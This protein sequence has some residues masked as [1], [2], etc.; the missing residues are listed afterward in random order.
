MTEPAAFSLAPTGALQALL[1]TIA[2]VD[3]TIPFIRPTGKFDEATLEAVMTFQKI[4]G[5]PVTG[6]VDH[7]TWDALVAAFLLAYQR[8]SPS[9]PIPLLSL[10]GQ[11]I[12]PGQSA[13]V[14]FPIQGM[15][16][17]LST[18]LA[19]VLPTPATGVLDEDT[20]ANLKWLQRHAGLPENGVLDQA[21]W[22]MLV[23]LFETFLTRKAVHVIDNAPPQP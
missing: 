10:G 3:Q 9:R 23:R 20:A 11:P 17:G 19:D 13:P 1:R 2:Y 18:M 8:L 15:F 7:A 12:S 21:T 16:T 6:V 5:L 4:S 22:E 14:L